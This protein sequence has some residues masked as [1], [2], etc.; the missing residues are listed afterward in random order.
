MQKISL[1]QILREIWDSRSEYLINR[2]VVSGEPYPPYGFDRFETDMYRSL[3]ESAAT[4]KAKWKKLKA[5]GIIVDIRTVTGAAMTGISIEA[6]YRFMTPDTRTAV[7]DAL[8]GAENTHTQTHT[9]FRG[10]DARA[11]EGAQR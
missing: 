6:F 1:D 10:A 9:P 5:N 3:I 7:R 2:A 8:A 11:R 4:V